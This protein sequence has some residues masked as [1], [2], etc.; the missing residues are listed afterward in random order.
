MSR[1]SIPCRA[2]SALLIAF[3]LGPTLLWAAVTSEELQATVLDA[4]RKVYP[5]LV[6]IQP[7]LKVYRSGERERMAVTGSGVII[8]EGGFVLTNNHVVE[9]AERVICTLHDQ[10]EVSAEVVG[11][12][13]FTDLAVIQLNLE[14]LEGKFVV[15][16]LVERNQSEFTAGLNNMNRG[17]QAQVLAEL[18]AKEAAR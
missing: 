8:S 7:V 15:G 13:V 6:H 2:A 14:E 11:R 5:A 12:D 4:K 10:Q 1:S 9:H 17:A 16:R 18:Q 3:L